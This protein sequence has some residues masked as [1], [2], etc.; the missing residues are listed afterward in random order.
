MPGSRLLRTTYIHSASGPLDTADLLGG[1]SDPARSGLR[2]VVARGLFCL[3]PELGLRRSRKR[4]PSAR[5]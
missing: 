1:H 2:S 4:E 5:S 3:G